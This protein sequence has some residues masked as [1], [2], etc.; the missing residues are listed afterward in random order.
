ME[1]SITCHSLQQ[2]VLY[3]FFS[4]NLYLHHDQPVKSTSALRSPCGYY[5]NLSHV[6]GHELFCP[7]NFLSEKSL[8][9]HACFVSVIASQAL[10]NMDSGD[11]NAQ[12]PQSLGSL[13]KQLNGVQVSCMIAP[14]H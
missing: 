1:T 12:S 6:P 3:F 2:F 7:P 10:K 11:Y 8:L 4:F 13:Q 5:Q 9:A 14:M